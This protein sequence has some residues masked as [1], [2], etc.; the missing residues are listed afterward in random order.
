MSYENLKSAFCSQKELWVAQTFIVPWLCG[1]P[2]RKNPLFLAT[3]TSS[4]IPLY[5]ACW[6]N[7]LF[8]ANMAAVR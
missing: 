5:E 2:R 3:N 8:L 4:G 7:L 6:Q 1:N